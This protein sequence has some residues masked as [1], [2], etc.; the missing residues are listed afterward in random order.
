M[1]GSRNASM[2]YRTLQGDSCWLTQFELSINVNQ[3][4]ALHKAPAR[5]SIITAR[6]GMAVA[7]S[8]VAMLL[9]SG[10]SA[11]VVPNANFQQ[12]NGEREGVA[13]EARRTIESLGFA[14]PGVGFESYLGRVSTV[15]GVP[16][17]FGT[18]PEEAA[19]AWLADFG[20]SLGAGQFGKG[21]LELRLRRAHDVSYGKFMVFVY[22]QLIDGVAVEYGSV[23]VIVRRDVLI[24][25][26]A[27]AAL[28]PNATNAVVLVTAKLAVPSAELDPV[29]LDPVQSDPDRLNGAR[30]LPATLTADQ[31]LTRAKASRVLRDLTKWSAPELIVY[32][33]EG[34]FDP[35]IE[36]RLVWSMQ[37][38]IPEIERRRNVRV[39][40]DARDGSIVN[41]RDQILHADV[42]GTVRAFATPGLSA[43]TA[44]NLPV[45]T[46]VPGARVV[47]GSGQE[48]FSAVNGSFQLT[49]LP[50]AGTSLLVGL[51]S[52]QWT[53]IVDTVTGT[54]I[55][56]AS[57][58]S[59]FSST[60]T[61]NQT[62]SQFT[63]A[64]ANAFIHSTLT[65]NFI[66]DRAPSFPGLNTLLPA[67]VNLITASNI[68]FCNAFYDGS[69]TN[70]FQFG[71][72]CNNTAFSTVVAHEYGHHI[73]NELNLAQGAFGEGFA[74]SVAMLLYDTG[75]VGENF[76]TSGGAIRNPQTANRQFPCTSTAIHT[77][78][79]ILGGSIREIRRNLIATSNTALSLEYS[80]QLFVDWSQITLGGQGINSAHPTTA[81]EILTMDDD[82]AVLLDG[83]PNYCQ[84][85]AAFAEHGIVSPSLALG[86]AFTFPDGLPTIITPNAIT[87][88]RVNVA[89]NGATPTP[90]TGLLFS[91]T[92]PGSPF[93]SVA[94]TQVT[95][96][97][98]VANIPGGACGVE[99]Q[100]FFQVGSSQ[101]NVPSP[102]IGCF[103]ATRTVPAGFTTLI[104]ND[105]FEVGSGWTVGET[106]AT[107]G[108]WVRVDPLG[109]SAQPADDFTTAPGVLCWVTGNGTNSNNPGE[110]DVDGGLT[111]LVSP[112]FDIAQFADARI[113]Y[114]RWYSNSAGAGA[115]ADTFRI[116]V[117][118]NGGQTW[119]NAETVGPTTQNAGGWL[120]AEWTL[121]QL[122]L[123]PTNQV[124]VR[125][126]AE[127]ASA[128]SLVEAALDAFN[129]IGLSCEPPQTCVGDFNND[130]GITGDDISAFFNAFEAGSSNSD[131]NQDGGIT[132]DDIAFFFQRYELGC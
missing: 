13:G 44:T 118:T 127:D 97:Q 10:A 43:D 28:R 24:T 34:D 77:C 79:Q 131:V 59:L 33:G 116:D 8:A 122:G 3:P 82:D 22:D 55:L 91:R 106:T 86:V 62:P 105:E 84:I 68:N 36:P 23:R 18:T 78:G 47:A 66:R 111:T 80:R 132:G 98:Y 16:M 6:A 104:T 76:T 101:G 119:T 12:G 2:Q 92:N 39:F 35:W 45:L 46:L 120:F 70:Y 38:E 93:T 124:V 95:T 4:N 40:I 58:D 26:P 112:I 11:Q 50:N 100:Y 81:I 75:I 85:S 73:V 15:Y 110:A 5:A 25:D 17:S 48:T 89:A 9:A 7:M 102:N 103:S 56:S 31:A 49:G 20:A 65:R 14:H 129:V 51:D 30:L 21:G 42:S 57:V 87:P 90:G 126:V 53:R 128:G 61:L 96:N 19:A 115:N 99:T 69:S 29:Q 32:F 114:R 74:D 88:V 109:T 113:N 117:S 71:G 63:T 67:R 130:G 64:Q 1:L 54:A 72:G 121:S 107:T 37:G 123:V 83:T 52:G 60:I 94:M 125:F 27:V 108:A 41:I